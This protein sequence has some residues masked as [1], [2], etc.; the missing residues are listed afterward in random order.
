LD[1][2]IHDVKVNRDY[3]ESRTAMLSGLGIYVMRF[4]NDDVVN[5]IETV[6]KK[7][8]EAAEMLS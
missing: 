1:G 6:L 7:I 4:N 8:S 2:G 3:D 5:N